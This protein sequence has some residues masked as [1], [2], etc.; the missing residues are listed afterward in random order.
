MSETSGERI[1]V[2]K[3]MGSRLRAARENKGLTQGQLAALI[4]ASRQ[5]IDRYEHGDLDIAVERLFDVAKILDIAM[6]DLFDA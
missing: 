4:E 3:N 5:Q 1:R 2:T 6:I